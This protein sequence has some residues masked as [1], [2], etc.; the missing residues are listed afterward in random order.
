MAEPALA[1]PHHHLRVADALSLGQPAE[2]VL[3]VSVGKVLEGHGLIVTKA[4]KMRALQSDA[5]RDLSKVQL[6]LVDWFEKGIW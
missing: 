1:S 4:G 3:E 6:F 2:W 5:G